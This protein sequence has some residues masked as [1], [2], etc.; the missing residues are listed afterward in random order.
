MIIVA[1][2]RP[3]G[4]AAAYTLTGKARDDHGY[5]VIDLSTVASM[6]LANPDRVRHTRGGH[7]LGQGSHGS[8]I[9]GSSFRAGRSR[10][11]FSC[12]A[13]VDSST[14]LAG[15]RHACAVPV[16]GVIRS[17]SLE[18]LRSA[19]RMLRWIKLAY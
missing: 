10:R 11:S 19:R 13:A 4:D 12:R 1:L 3:R 8:A 16:V 15:A 18:R 7:R 5:L 6:G 2:S 17:P 14:S 9:G